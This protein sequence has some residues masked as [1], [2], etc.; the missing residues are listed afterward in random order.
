M[1]EPAS[2]IPAEALRMPETLCGEG[3]LGHSGLCGP[4]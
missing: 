2:A 1:P 3:E 4:W